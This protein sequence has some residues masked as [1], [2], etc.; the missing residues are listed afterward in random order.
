MAKNN[1]EKGFSHKILERNVSLLGLFALVAVHA[2]AAAKAEQG[3]ALNRV[4]FAAHQLV[5]LA[6]DTIVSLP[7][8]SS[9]TL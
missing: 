4:N 9:L 5:Q 7:M 1:A 8:V 6:A 2:F 3:L